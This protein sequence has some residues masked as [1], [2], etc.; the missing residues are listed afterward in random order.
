MVADV[1]KSKSATLATK[2]I[3]DHIIHKFGVPSFITTHQG[4]EF[5][6]NVSNELFNEFGIRRIRSSSYNSGSN[7]EIERRWRIINKYMSRHTSTYDDT[8]SLLPR[9][10]F[11][12]N[13]TPSST[14]MQVPAYL[15]F[16]FLPNT[17]ILFKN[18]KP[19]N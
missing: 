7:G 1:V 4:D 19:A 16:S 17:P 11:M 3:M 8:A 10:V 18:F 5:N 13:N 2:F 9:A 12:V 6:D 14:T 15:T